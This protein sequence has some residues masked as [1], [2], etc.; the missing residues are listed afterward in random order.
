MATKT[1]QSRAVAWHKIGC[2]SIITTLEWQK[3]MVE[4]REKRRERKAQ[5]QKNKNKKYCSSKS[6]HAAR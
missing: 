5:K 2:L 6:A 1:S 4:Y 3:N